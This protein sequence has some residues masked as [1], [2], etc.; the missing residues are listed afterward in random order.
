[1][2]QKSLDKLK[3]IKMVLFI[4][5]VIFAIYF[6]LKVSI[7][8]LPIIIGFVLST[9]ID[10]LVRLAIKKLKLPRKIASFISIILMLST[11]G[12]L[13]FLIISKLSSEIISIYHVFP[14]YFTETY[15]NI[16]NLVNKSDIIIS[17][18][19]IELRSTIQ[20]IIVSLTQTVKQWMFNVL[21]SIVNTAI[22]IPEAFIF[23]IVTILSTYFFSSD[24]EKITL[25]FRKHLPDSWMD[26]LKSIKDNVF[27]A[28][29]SYFK[30]QMII[31]S[32]TFSELFIGFSII[33]IKYS[34][35]LSIT[36]AIVDIMP[37][38]GT[39]GVLI[40]WALYNFIIG[41]TKLGISL[42]ILYVVVL[43]VR[44]LIEPKIVGQ[45]IGLHP[46]ITLTAMYTG[47]QIFGVLGMILG[48][49][50]V[51]VLKN[52]FSGVLKTGFLKEFLNRITPPKD[53]L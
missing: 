26:K 28:L 22:S 52:I 9:F 42:L 1:M 17:A 31:M 19:P 15:N 3:N 14:N 21:K 29:I 20:S 37:V 23:T 33:G 40:P 12:F 25:N 47:L 13:I 8:I 4:I 51:L 16:N 32:I 39:G 36:I 53:N 24:R 48:P 43:L 34:L 35:L 38:L 7:Y 30:A 41:D 45:Q 6:A 50:T 5:G 46:L 49:I 2:E 10:P 18:I 11:V 27:S 44:Q